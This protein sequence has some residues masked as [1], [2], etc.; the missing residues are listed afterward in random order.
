MMQL[1]CKPA[2]V[3]QERDFFQKEAAAFLAKERK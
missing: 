1:R 3:K 2:K